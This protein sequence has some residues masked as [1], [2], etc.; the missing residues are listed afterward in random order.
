MSGWRDN[1]SQFNHGVTSIRFFTNVQVLMGGQWWFP[2]M[3]TRL[4]CPCG[5]Q[6]L[7]SIEDGG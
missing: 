5:V 4:I 7:P 6:V 1:Y 2:V 3:P